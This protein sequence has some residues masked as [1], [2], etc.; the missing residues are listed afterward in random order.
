MHNAY[1]IYIYI[2]VYMGHSIVVA[3]Y[4]CIDTYLSRNLSKQ[5]TLVLH[6][7]TVITN[8]C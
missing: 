8:N 4:A 1:N 5:G 6:Y 7:E 3:L 2:T